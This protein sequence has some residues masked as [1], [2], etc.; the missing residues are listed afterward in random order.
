M[1]DTQG[2]VWIGT[3]GDGLVRY[4]PHTGSSKQYV[5]TSTPITSISSNDVQS[6]AV[7][8]DGIIWVGTTYGLDQFDSIHETFTNFRDISSIPAVISRSVINSLFIEDESIWV[9]TNA[10]LFLFDLTAMQAFEV[11]NKSGLPPTVRIPVKDVMRSRNGNLWVATQDFGVFRISP[12]H[13]S[14]EQISANPR[15]PKAI[16]DNRILC[17]LEDRSG[18]IWFGTGSEYI[19]QLDPLRNR[20][21][22]LTYAPWTKNQLSESRVWAVE[23]GKAGDLWIGT[24]GGGLNRFNTRT[25]IMQ[26]YQ[27][28][29]DNPISLGD[30][31]VRS[32]LFDRTGLLWIGTDKGLSVYNDLTRTFTKVTLTQVIEDEDFGYRTANSNKTM[33]ILVIRQDHSNMLW[34]GTA[35]SG[36][37]QYDPKTGNTNH[38]EYLKGYYNSLPSNTVWALYPDKDNILWIGTDR[39]LARLDTAKKQ[40]QLYLPLTNT[41]GSISDGRVFSIYRD[42]SGV[43]WIGTSSGLNRFIEGMGQFKVYREKD[44]LPNDYIYSIQED[45]QKKLW[46]STNKGISRFDPSS[47]T[48]VNFNEIDGLVSNEFNR[49]SGTH[50]SS[51]TIYFGGV[52]GISYFQP[53]EISTNTYTPNI[54]LSSITQGGDLLEKDV[55]TEL[56]TS[57]HLIWPKN[58]FEFTFHNLF[59]SK[60]ESFSYAYKLEPFDQEW[61]STQ[62][63]GY[64]RYTNLPGGDYRLQLASVDADGHFVNVKEVLEVKVIPPLWESKWFQVLLVAILIAA[65]ILGVSIR[66]RT[67]RK[68]N[69]ELSKLVDLRTKEINQRRQV[70]EGLRDILIRINS[71]QSLEQSLQFIANQIQQILPADQVVIF[72]CCTE[73]K[74]ENDL[75]IQANKADQ[76]DKSDLEGLRRIADKTISSREVITVSKAHWISE[77]PD[78]PIFA[79]LNQYET[80]ILIPAI[81]EDSV[82]A[83]LLV[84]MKS[85]VVWGDED[86][87]VLTSFS[88]QIALVLGNAQLRQNAADLGHHER[89]KSSCSRYARCSNA[90]ALFRKFVG[91]SLSQC[92]GK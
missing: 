55:P 70:A 88:E 90:N 76:I 87:E 46:L 47:E 65:I 41:R 33:P 45:D 34:I 49:G 79:P 9:G 78:N 23:T 51:G 11:L 91:R 30:Q 12:D 24:D 22:N 20:F 44:G 13:T 7:G 81:L 69:I 67:M 35:N 42:S 29:P 66:T 21:H 59:T 31:Q 89:K 60:A 32:L 28:N 52:N 71:N 80:G 92:L 86:I 50:D 63:E 14:V 40:I 83:V 27:H 16:S 57:V 64:G 15:D 3:L 6:L 61:V 25:K 82:Q 56:I 17:I 18:V 19:N 38:Y 58:Y 84:L 39:G 72:G 37:Y 62:K 68:R 77:N 8:K 75:H 73:L 48:F 36:L 4:D 2:V 1:V 53:D 74:T 10:G 5:N 54:I 85:E 43:L 26:Y